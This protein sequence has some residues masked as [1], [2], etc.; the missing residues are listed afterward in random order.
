MGPWG[1]PDH[2]YPNG[3][4]FNNNIDP[5]MKIIKVLQIHY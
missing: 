4:S 3:I 2:D 1:L 5:N